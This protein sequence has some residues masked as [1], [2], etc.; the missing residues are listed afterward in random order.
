MYAIIE[1]DGSSH[2]KAKGFG[3]EHRTL[4]AITKLLEGQAI[5]YDHLEKIGALAREGFSRGPQMTRKV[6]SLKAQIQKR[7]FTA[8]GSS[9][10]IRL[11][12]W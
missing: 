2:V 12:M 7:E 11:E 10:P 9:K 4:Q 3:R 8:D 6:K 5:A 1:E